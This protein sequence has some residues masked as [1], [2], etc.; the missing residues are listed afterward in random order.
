MTEYPEA[1]QDQL[2]CAG[3]YWRG[4]G[5]LGATGASHRRLQE[6]HRCR[7]GADPGMA[8]EKDPRRSRPCETSAIFFIYILKPF[9]FN[10]H[11]S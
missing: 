5:G 10:F 11:I 4:S 8:G 6:G 3:V 7:S 1:R 2:Q 9:F